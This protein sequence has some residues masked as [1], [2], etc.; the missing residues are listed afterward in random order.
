MAEKLCNFSLREAWL[1]LTDDVII[2]TIIVN[3]LGILFKKGN[4]TV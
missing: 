3:I 1:Y 4:V 2:K